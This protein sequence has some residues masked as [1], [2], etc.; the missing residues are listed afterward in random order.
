MDGEDLPETSSATWLTGWC[1]ARCIAG[2][3]VIRPGALRCRMHEFMFATGIECSYPTIGGGRWRHDQLADTKHYHYWRRD[4]EL[5]RELGLKYLR[6]GP[7]FHLMYLGEDKYEWSF[8]DQVSAAM[9]Q[10]GIEPII[11]L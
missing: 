1:S 11:D 5:V 4:L 2:P 3:S 8:M 7:P 10:L 9:Q 6:Y